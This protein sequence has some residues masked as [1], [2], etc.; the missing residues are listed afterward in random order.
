AHLY[1]GRVTRAAVGKSN[2]RRARNAGREAASS[3]LS[4]ISS[5]RAELVLVFA[6]SGYDQ[7]EL[8]GGVT[9]IMG[10]TPLSGCSGEGLIT[11]LGS[12]EGSYAVAVMAITSDRIQFDT[13]Q[14]RGLSKEPRI[15]GEA[16][17]EEM[18]R[19]NGRGRCLLLFPDGLMGDSSAFLG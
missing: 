11:Q 13:Y 3:A 8:L 7:V 10:D 17:A 2:N 9:D 4:Q 1:I 5:S 15:C 18:R 16:L 12:D 14:V 6:T 19:S